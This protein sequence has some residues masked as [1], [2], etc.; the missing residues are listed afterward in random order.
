MS[1]VTLKVRNTSYS[2]WE[3]VNVSKSLLQL[4]GSFSFS[5]TNLLAYKPEQFSIQLGDPCTV[6]IDGQLLITGYIDEMPI[7][8]DSETHTIQVTGRDKTGDLVDCSYV[9]TPNEWKDQSI[10]N[11]VK[12][13]CA[14]GDSTKFDIS[15]VV[16]DSVASEAAVEVDFAVEQ[17][18]TVLDEISRL[19]MSKAI[20]PVTYGDGKLTL[21]RGGA[22]EKAK[23]NL[24]LGANIK[25]GIIDQSNL[26]RFSRY[27][28]KG[29]DTVTKKKSWASTKVDPSAEATDEVIDR[30]RPLIIL[31]DRSMDIKK[32]EE[33]ALWESRV[34]AGQS[35]KIEYTVQGWTQSNGKVWPLNSLVR[36]KD[37]FF[38]G[39]DTRLISGLE[40]STN[41]TSGTVTRIT[42][43][44][45]NTFD[46][47]EV[48]IKEEDTESLIQRQIRKQR[49]LGQ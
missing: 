6:E 37:K 13:L 20:L 39:D 46:L 41:N 30:Y 24:E 9:E 21:T 42:V 17:S 5:A 19:C 29:Q 25:A 33:R 45:K 14:S 34:R 47:I 43:V 48:P 8:Y 16:D 49:E 32:C 4:A 28:V 2:G 44:P 18:A 11:I 27:I 36:I 40:F 23:D 15:V 31:P 10:E 12:I 26:E 38:G 22:N 3:T 35:R 1:E 7:S